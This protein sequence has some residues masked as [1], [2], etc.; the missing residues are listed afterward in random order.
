M[1]KFL[2]TR[3]DG[4][5]L[6]GLGLS[7]GNVEKLQAGHPIL[8]KQEAMGLPFDIVILYGETEESMVDGLKSHGMEF[9][10]VDQWK[11]E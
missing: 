10:P 7:A 3:P 8:I 5:Q 11:P 2:A 9:P 4:R 6:V 1:I